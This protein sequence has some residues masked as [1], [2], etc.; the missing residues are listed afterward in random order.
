MGRKG[1][2]AAVSAVVEETWK[3][4]DRVTVDFDGTTY[5]GTVVKVKQRI[6]IVDFDDG[7]QREIDLERLIRA[8]KGFRQGQ[9]RPPAGD[10]GDDS[11]DGE[12]LREPDGDIKFNPPPKGTRGMHHYPLSWSPDGLAFNC[13]AAPDGE[14]AAISPTGDDLIHR[15]RDAKNRAVHFWGSWRK[16]D[17]MRMDDAN[18]V[19]KD[20]VAGW[21]IDMY[22]RIEYEVAGVKKKDEYTVESLRYEAGPDQK[23]PRLNMHALNS[24]I[25][26]AIR[27]WFFLE[28]RGDKQTLIQL[29]RAATQPVLKVPDLTWLDRFMLK[30]R[31][32]RETA[33]RSGGQRMIVIDTGIEGQ[34]TVS[35][36]MDFTQQA[37]QLDG[38]R[39]P[40]IFEGGAIDAA[41]TR[42]ARAARS[43]R[44]ESKASTVD[45]SNLNS[46]KE[47]LVELNAKAK[48]GDR[49]AKSEA[50][51]L[52]SALRSMGVRGGAR[53]TTQ[54]STDDDGD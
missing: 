32:V 2:R 7:D 26:A 39:P 31:E 40:G 17:F 15:V 41:A 50:R 21:A 8:P 9:P 23:D 45:A 48:A 24:D 54:T 44:P 49:S 28:L 4:D 34:P 33:L 42:G 6:A 38:A 10:N 13:W 5:G 36:H 11:E 18:R 19:V 51:K 35:L 3:A 14:D 25:C 53:A 29:K 27:K 12:I 46:L 52:R 16:T 47:K 43:H 22:A 1:K 20:R 30:C 37:I